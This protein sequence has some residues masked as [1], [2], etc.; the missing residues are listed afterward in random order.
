[1]SRPSGIAR[2]GRLLTAVFAIAGGISILTLATPVTSLLG[3]RL[4]GPITEPTG[5][6]LIVLTAA[7]PVD[8][9]LSESSYWRSV[10]AVRAWHTGAFNRILL[11]GQQS[12]VMKHFLVSEGIPA[13]R[14]DLEDR[15]NTTRE[16]ALFAAAMLHPPV[17]P[18]PVLMTSD[19]HMLR[20][21]K[22]FEKAGLPVAARPIPDAI[23]RSAAWYNRPTILVVELQEMVKLAGYRLRGWI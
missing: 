15:S 11:S 2:L 8:G 12:S 16:S 14:I 7:T 20:A 1:M 10:Y 13:D 19:Y 6:L 4:A 18:P 9:I 23:K 5:P 22:C 21:R 17:T 3:H